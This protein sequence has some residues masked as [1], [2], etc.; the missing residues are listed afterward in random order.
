M[1]IP[2]LRSNLGTM[3]YGL[4]SNV[5]VRLLNYLLGGRLSKKKNLE[6]LAAQAK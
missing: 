1:H 2:P 3:G 6:A 4:V 5:R